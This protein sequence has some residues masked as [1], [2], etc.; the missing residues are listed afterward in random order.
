LL[1][2]PEQPTE[3]VISSLRKAN[4]CEVNAVPKLKTG[5]IA[6]TS[7]KDADFAAA[8]KADPDATP[9]TDAEWAQ[10]KLPVRRSRPLGSGIE[11]LVTLCLD[12]EVVE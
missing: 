5:A 10:M 7:D 12:V 11:T 3:R 2:Q 1:R 8:A 4:A 9:F 6:L